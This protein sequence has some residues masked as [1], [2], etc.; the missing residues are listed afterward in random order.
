MKTTLIIPNSPARRERRMRQRS[1]LIWR[2]THPAAE[3]GRGV[4]LFSN[5]RLLDGAT[6][7]ALR[8]DLG[9]WLE[10]TDPARVREALG[11]SERE[12]GIYR[13]TPEQS[14]LLSGRRVKV[15]YCH[16]EE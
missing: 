16:T 4:L 1:R 14:A 8:D 15:C 5:G 11:A 13:V 9:A 6:F 12:A 7:R 2:T 3:P 10:T